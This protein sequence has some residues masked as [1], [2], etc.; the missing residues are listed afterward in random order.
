M[1]NDNL[2]NNKVN[3]RYTITQRSYRSNKSIITKE[4]RK[5]K[6]IETITK[7]LENNE[8]LIIKE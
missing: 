7:Q 6:A 8:N 4:D 2:P 5:K 3:N 1:K